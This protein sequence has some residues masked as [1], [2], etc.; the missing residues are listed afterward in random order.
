MSITRQ[1]LGHWGEA[2]AAQYLIA[3]GYTIVDR[4]V[5]TPYGEIDLVVKDEEVLV[6]VEVKT[7][8][9][10]SFGNAEESITDKKLQHM[11]DSAEAYLQEHLEHSGDWRIDVIAIHASKKDTP[12]ITHF[13]N[14]TI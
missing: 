9:G 6:F 12:E 10:R 11:I 2:R 13:K 14:A 8:S 4:N 3:K 5:R 1:E 7:R